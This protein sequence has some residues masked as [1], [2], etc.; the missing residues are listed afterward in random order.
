MNPLYSSLNSPLKLT[1]LHSEDFITRIHRT[2]VEIHHQQFQHNHTASVTTDGYSRAYH[3]GA[4]R[5]AE[6]Q[7]GVRRKETSTCSV[8]AQHISN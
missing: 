1:I 7:D 4:A 3:P 8:I 6:K 2:P 5:K